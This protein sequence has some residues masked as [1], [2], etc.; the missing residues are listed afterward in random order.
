MGGD[1]IGAGAGAGAGAEGR[2]GR[3]GAGAPLGV[4]LAEVRA[5]A[6]SRG[7]ARGRVEA[8]AGPG[9]RWRAA[10]AW[11]RGSGVALEARLGAWFNAR[12]EVPALR[13]HVGLEGAAGGFRFGAKQRFREGRLRAPELRGKVVQGLPRGLQLTLEAK[14]D[15][16]KMKGSTGACLRHGKRTLTYAQ[17]EGNQKYTLETGALPVGAPYLKSAGVAW[18]LKDG[19]EAFAGGDFGRL[20]CGLTAKTTVSQSS[21]K[22]AVDY[23]CAQVPLT[24]AGVPA[25]APEVHL[26]GRFSSKRR[27]HQTLEIDTKW[28]F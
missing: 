1:L 18:S 27:D 17:G 16:E 10:A 11:G 13:G 19:R 20:L 8:C 26:K 25:G 4:E 7:R 14:W 9:G 5:G 12:C 3:G 24:L 15:E 23:K 2:G 6:D 28:S 22:V 21:A